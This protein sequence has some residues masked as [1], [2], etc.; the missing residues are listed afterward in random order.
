VGAERHG[1]LVHSEKK[2]GSVVDQ[3]FNREY[4]PEKSTDSCWR[5]RESFVRGHSRKLRQTAVYWILCWGILFALTS[6]IDARLE[7]LASQSLI[8]H[9]RSFSARTGKA[10]QSLNS[11]TSREPHENESSGSYTHLVQQRDSSDLKRRPYDLSAP[12]R[13]ETDQESACLRKIREMFPPVVLSISAL[14]LD[15][16][17]LDQREHTIVIPLREPHEEIR[18]IWFDADTNTEGL[19]IIRLLRTGKS[20]P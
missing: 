6:S 13:K 16:A 4:L 14:D 2:Q 1:F 3:E 17:R 11:N 8:P 15:Q 19:E 10:M 18:A 9:L 20:A 7:S 5:E 12:D